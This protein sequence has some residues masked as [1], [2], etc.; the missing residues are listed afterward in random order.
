MLTTYKAVLR[1]DR[2]EWM[3]TAPH[4]RRR[5]DPVEV[6]VRILP[7]TSARSGEKMA[8]ALEKLAK[9]D[10]DTAIVDPVDWQRE[11][12]RDRPLP[13]REP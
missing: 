11:M 10:A 4:G 7:K 9:M 1:G 12:R 8:A 6:E 5:E 2:L 3:G 13:G